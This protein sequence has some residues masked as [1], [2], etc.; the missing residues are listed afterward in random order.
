MLPRQGP[1]GDGGDIVPRTASDCLELLLATAVTTLPLVELLVQVQV[2]VQVAVT[3]GSE[4]VVRWLRVIAMRRVK[5][6]SRRT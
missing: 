1:N 6:G 5:A 3:S 4:E 2:L